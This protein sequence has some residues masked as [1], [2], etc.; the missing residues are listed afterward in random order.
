MCGPTHQGTPVERDAEE[1][2]RPP[3]EP[4][5]EWV[6]QHGDNR[7]YAEGNR[8]GVK[9]DEDAEGDER[10]KRHPERSFFRGD[11]A[12]WDRTG[13]CSCD[14]R[15]KVPIRDVI[16]CA[17]RTTHQERPDRATD[18]NPEVEK[19]NAVCLENGERKAPPAWQEQEPC[20][21]GSIRAG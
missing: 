3:C 19:A 16:P 13:P 1:Y 7:H 17:A 12:R 20:S 15:V 6:D 2:L 9:A 18:G 10:L 14:C 21:D 11:L 4:F 8:E 5:R